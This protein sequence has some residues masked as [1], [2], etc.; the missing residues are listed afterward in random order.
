MTKED[1]K[2]ILLN[3]IKI[4]EHYGVKKQ[5]II[6]IEEM[7]ELTKNICKWAREYD[8]LEGDVDTQLKMGLEEEITDVMICLDQLKYILNF[9][10]D[11]LMKE[12]KYKVDRQLER[13]KSERD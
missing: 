6:W 10:E 8:K 7:S 11:A 12:Y 4:A 13:I 5:M 2:D 1:Y 9:D 3:N